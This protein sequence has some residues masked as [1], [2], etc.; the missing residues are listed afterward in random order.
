M[1]NAFSEWSGLLLS[2]RILI[3]LLLFILIGVGLLIAHSIPRARAERLM[4]KGNDLVLAGAAR[5]GIALMGKAIA[6]QPNSVGM[7]RSLGY[8]YAAVGNI[9]AAIASHE[10]V[11]EIDP[12][13][14]YALYD[15]AGLYEEVD[16]DRAISYYKAAGEADT[17]VR[18][19]ALNKLAR[20]YLLTNRLEK[21]KETLNSI[22][23]IDM[24]SRAF[25]LALFLM[26][27]GWLSYLENDL[28]DSREF[29]E[30]AI[31]ANSDDEDAYCLLALV[32][33]ELGLDNSEEKL[34]CFQSS[35]SRPEVK[36]WKRQLDLSVM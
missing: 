24:P 11:L 13:N 26:H 1:D 17:S 35:A 27:K 5:E 33:A 34:V 12:A 21:A 20:A 10:K 36:A 15:L 22:G 7:T 14:T 30:R 4:D 9:E 16:M 25:F 3:V 2:N 6:I 31:E 18:P 19:S 28:E 8:A 29:L 32:R 23:G